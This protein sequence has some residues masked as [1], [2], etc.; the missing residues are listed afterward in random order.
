MKYKVGDK[1]K[2]KTW[3]SM[4]KEFGVNSEGSIKGS[5][6]FTKKMEEDI[7][8]DVHSREVTIRQIGVEWISDCYIVEELNKYL[9]GNYYKDW[10]LDDW[11]VEEIYH[12]PINNRWE[13]LDL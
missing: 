9:R 2:I 10:K 7:N 8:R 1:V 13:L 11:M 3:E 5:L 12:V 4:E 6:L